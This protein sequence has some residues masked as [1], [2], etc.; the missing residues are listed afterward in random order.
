MD[1]NWSDISRGAKY[2]ARENSSTAGIIGTGE[3]GRAQLLSLSKVRKIKKVFAHS[4]R[5][6]D[7]EYSKIIAERLG[8]EVIASETIEEVS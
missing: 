6:K 3:Q 5:R 8:I 2:L 4:G 1:E 7:S